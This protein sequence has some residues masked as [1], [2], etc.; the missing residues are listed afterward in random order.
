MVIYCR[1]VIKSFGISSNQVNLQNVLEGQDAISEEVSEIERSHSYYDWR[2]EMGIVIIVLSVI[3]VTLI[4]DIYF[5]WSLYIHF[6][7]HLVE[8]DRNKH[9]QW[10]TLGLW[11]LMSFKQ[12]YTNT[13]DDGNLSDAEDEMTPQ[14]HGRYEDDSND[15]YGGSS[16]VALPAVT[17][18]SSEAP[19]SRPTEEAK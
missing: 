10:F 17:E 3:I 6:L 13:H 14:N 2:H 11:D 9:F 19:S 15:S 1:M 4:L 5:I 16:N 7:I 8:N 12:V 18:S